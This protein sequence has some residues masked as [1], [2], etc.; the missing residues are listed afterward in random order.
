MEFSELL[1]KRYSVRAY[2]SDEVEAKKLQR[3]LEAARLAPTAANR[4]SFQLLVV[5][6]KGREE[7]LRKAYPQLWFVQA[8][9]II[10]A[11]G[12]P[13]NNWVRMDG[14]NYNDV[15]VVIVMDH[16]ILAAANEGLGTCWIG[17]FNP[18]KAKEIF[19]L[20]ADVE[21]VALTPLGYPDDWGGGEGSLAILFD[22]DLGASG[23]HH[24]LDCQHHSR[25]QT[26]PA[27]RLA[28]KL[29]EIREKE[30]LAAAEIL[31]VSEVIFLRYPDQGLENSYELRRDIVRQIRIYRPD[32]VVTVDPHGRYMDHRDHRMTGCATVEAV[33]PAAASACTFPELLAEGLEPHRVKELL[34]SGRTE[35]NYFVDISETIDIKVA[36]IRCH[37]SQVGDRSDFGEMLKNSRSICPSDARLVKRVSCPSR[38]R[39]SVSTSSPR[40]SHIESSIRYVS[41]V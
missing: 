29:V 2:K 4:Q 35:Q 10:C 16:L 3:V 1:Q 33:Y 17:A 13:K 36:A 32:T 40:S 9:L 26:H 7:E 6:T 22:D 31:G 23:I 24:R 15:D 18:E 11:C 38:G 27:I 25:P 12:L 30:Q 8:P 14:K 20:P 21:P 39:T 5:H 37:R 34:F 19:Q 41:S 28:E